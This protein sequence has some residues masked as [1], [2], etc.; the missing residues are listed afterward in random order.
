M[1]PVS[2]PVL[3]LRGN[4]TIVPAA[5]PARALEFRLRALHPVIDAEVAA[6]RLKPGLRASTVRV[7]L[8]VTVICSACATPP[9]PVRRH[10]VLELSTVGVAAW[11][12]SRRGYC[13][14][15]C[16]SIQFISWLAIVPIG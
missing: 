8:S 16:A 14:C 13:F 12:G 6:L 7:V 15:S 1:E 3:P 5:S 2:A 11:P 4:M 10:G 9:Q